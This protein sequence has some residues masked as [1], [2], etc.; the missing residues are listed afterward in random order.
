MIF[1]ALA[2]FSHQ[3]DKYPTQT[4]R[5]ASNTPIGTLTESEWHQDTPP[6]HLL[7]CH[8]SVSQQSADISPCCNHPET[9]KDNSH[10]RRRKL[11]KVKPEYQQLRYEPPPVETIPSPR[12]ESILS[13]HSRTLLLDPSRTASSNYAPQRTPN[14]LE[15]RHKM[16]RMASMAASSSF[17]FMALEVSNSESPHSS[18]RV[19]SPYKPAF[20]H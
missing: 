6:S 9:R 12:P 17:G 10:V 5:N 1:R 2:V 19:I 4:F 20:S 7:S 11:R 16:R 15:K 18:I 8:H 13:T 14:K 3:E